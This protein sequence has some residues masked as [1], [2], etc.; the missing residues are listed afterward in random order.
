MPDANRI[1]QRW[2]AL[3]NG[4]MEELDLVA[5][6][7]VVHA[8]LVGQSTERPLVGRES[9]RSWMATAQAMLPAVRFSIEVGPLVDKALIAVRWRGEGPHGQ[10]YVSFTGMDLLRI[11]EGRIA[12]LWTNA[13]TMLMLQQI[14]LLPSA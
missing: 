9:L 4:N 11:A 14:G 2:L 10:S 13:D 8:V 1:V 3:W 12:E 5:D 6:A 7:V